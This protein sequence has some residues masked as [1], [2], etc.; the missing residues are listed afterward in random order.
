MPPAVPTAH[1]DPL[2]PAALRPRRAPDASP[3]RTT[4]RA[5]APR[6]LIG[7]GVSAPLFIGLPQVQ[8]AVRSLDAARR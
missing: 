6:P 4:R 1:P 5:P 8:E 2:E 3:A 7:A